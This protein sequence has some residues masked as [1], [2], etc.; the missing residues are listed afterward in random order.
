MK[1][2]TFLLG[3]V[4]IGSVL[5]SLTSCQ[6][7]QPDE[8]VEAPAGEIED[9]V[10]RLLDE[11][12]VLKDE[13]PIVDG[14]VNDGVEEN[15]PDSEIPSDTIDEEKG[16]DQD[17]SES[18]ANV[19]LIEEAK[20]NKFT[21]MS[22]FSGKYYHTYYQRINNYLVDKLGE[23][24]DAKDN[25]VEALR[26]VDVLEKTRFK[27]PNLLRALKQLTALTK[28]G[29]E[30]MCTRNA[31]GILR[32]NDLATQGRAHKRQTKLGALRRVDKI[33]YH[34][35]IQHAIDCYRHYPRKFAQKR[36]QLDQ[37]QMS[38]VEPLFD[39]VFQ[40]VLRPAS[41]MGFF[42]NPNFKNN[43]DPTELVR[44]ITSLDRDDVAE[45][46]LMKLRFYARNDPDSKYLEHV[47]DDRS[48]KYIINE[49]KVKELYEKYIVKPCEHYI[50][51]LGFDVFIP[52][53]FDLMM[54]EP[55]DR[56][57]LKD[58]QTIEFYVGYAKFR[59]CNLLVYQDKKALARRIVR[60]V[61]KQ[62]EPR[63]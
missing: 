33:V 59:A 7:T 13:L 9:N 3:S 12:E 40:T 41:V 4:V 55:E 8:V 11:I 29:G 52:M 60:A 38:Y 5:V 54:L 51:Q 61:H 48:G 17:T 25:M 49:T 31:Y 42:A 39:H 19:E 36:A 63:V 18:N 1:L 43:I 23:N 16:G 50:E 45:A 28:I 24:D 2:L 35:S 10:T 21:I 53:R 56:Y 32:K 26:W 34:Y 47:N 15:G 37:V 58:D 30:N 20:D 44:D 57:Q 62:A 6:D 22:L 14:Q 27:D 46:T